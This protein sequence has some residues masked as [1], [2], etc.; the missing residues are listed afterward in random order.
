MATG[1]LPHQSTTELPTFT[2]LVDGTPLDLTIEVLAITVET[3][4]NRIPKA[5]LILKDGNPAEEDFPISNE[6][7]FAPGAEVIINAGYVSL[8]AE[9]FTGVVVRHG[10]EFEQDTGPVLTVEC[11]D[12]AVK[13][14]ITR[15]NKYY[16]D[17]PDSD[18][19][20][21]LIEAHGLTAEV[22]AT[23]VTHTEMVQHY[24]T[25]FDFTITRAEF[26]GMLAFIS[27]GTVKIDKPDLAASPKFDLMYGHNLYDFKAE[28]DS[29]F[30]YPAVKSYS[31]DYSAQEL[32]EKEGSVDSFTEQGDISSDDLS[33]EMGIDHLHLQHIGRVP[34]EELE[35]WAN[36]TLLRSR[37]AKIKGHARFQ[38]LADVFPGDVVNLDGV[39]NRFNGPVFVSAVL[40]EITGANWETEIDFGLSKDWLYER[41]DDLSDTPSSGLIPGIHGLAIGKVKNIHEDPDGEYRVQ[42]WMPTISTEEDG[43]WARVATLDA[44]DGR[45]T[46]FR[47]ELEDE[48]ILGFL[49]GDPRDPVILGMLHSSSLP[50]PLEPAEENAEKGIVTKSGIKLLFE[51]EKIE[52]TIETPNGNTLVLSDDQGSIT[53]E[54]ENGNTIEMTSDGITLSSAK[55]LILEASGDV[56]VSGTNVEIAA[57]ANFKAEGAGGA[58][59]ST[60]ATA[61]LK[62]SIV[63]IN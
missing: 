30:Q 32:I 11:W 21:E 28:M 48:V 41:Y 60:S 23:D 10:V 40:H 63:Q 9:I 25:D 42:V 1:T 49:N 3:G 57:N 58:E 31:W 53:L 24:C 17:K 36:A 43:I 35:T 44:G 45:G 2:V 56:K 61:V 8:E 19:I 38:G 27:A 20:T 26:N 18:I 14:T 13:M 55:D 59:V 37:M 6:D 52:F 46:F 16:Y 34:D 50:S 47:P 5:V 39:G 29:R 12:E 22:T 7:L 4:V 54:D 51:D 62:G 15:N 33:A